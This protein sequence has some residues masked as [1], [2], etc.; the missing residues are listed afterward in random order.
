MQLGSALHVGLAASALSSC[1][2]AKLARKSMR[3]CDGKSPI[4]MGDKV[5][6]K[7]RCVSTKRSHYRS[8]DCSRVL[9]HLL[10]NH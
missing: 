5:I 9:L 3:H 8:I 6:L 7:V 4:S 1:G 10:E 2:P